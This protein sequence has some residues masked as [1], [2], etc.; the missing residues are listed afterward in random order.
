MS[1]VTF[2]TYGTILAHILCRRRASLAEVLADL[3]VDPAEFERDEPA[4]R[5]E[6]AGAWVARRGISAMKFAAALATELQ[7]LGP[8]RGDGA[9]PPPPEAVPR[10]AAPPEVRETEMPSYLQA[11]PAGGGSLAAPFLAP[12]PATAPPVGSAAPVAPPVM[13]RKEVGPA[14]PLAGTADMNLSAIMSTIQQ[15]GLP[16]AHGTSTAP[17]A[18]QAPEP[19]VAPEKRVPV[20][21]GTVGADF[22][23]VVAAVKKGALPFSRPEQPH[24]GHAETGEEPDLAQ[25]PL[26]TFAEV[27]GALA[28]GESRDAALARHGL[29]SAAFDLLAKAWAQRFQREPQLLE[30]FKELAKISA[31]IGRGGG[32]QR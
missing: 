5:R 1:T 22:S 31:A 21:S 11:L 13:V 18:A 28:R 9:A 29:T 30:R 7:R 12:P 14:S 4:L 26:E 23:D 16:F 6:L 25:L 10:L 24:A 27:S 15:G 20:G 8:L 19:A 2:E 17:G 32:G 3:H